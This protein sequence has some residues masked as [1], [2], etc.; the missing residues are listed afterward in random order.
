MRSSKEL[1]PGGHDGLAPLSKIRE[2]RKDEKGAGSEARSSNAN[3]EAKQE[4]LGARLDMKPL[5]LNNIDSVS[6]SEQKRS[7]KYP[8]KSGKADSQVQMASPERKA[9]VVGPPGK[10]EPMIQSTIVPGDL[11]KSTEARYRTAEPPAGTTIQ[12]T[13]KSPAAYAHPVSVKIQ[14]KLVKPGQ[15]MHESLDSEV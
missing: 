8:D 2:E 5:D 6:L 15:T 4:S 14:D 9:S 13:D 12:G 10:T 3:S 1:T 7:G 11:P